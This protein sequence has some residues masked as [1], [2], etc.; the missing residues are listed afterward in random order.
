VIFSVGV[1]SCGTEGV[2]GAMDDG[3]RYLLGKAAQQ[4]FLGLIDARRID[5]SAWQD[6]FFAIHN[7]GVAVD[8]EG[9]AAAAIGA[10]HCGGN[11]VKILVSDLKQE[12]LVVARKMSLHTA[13]YTEPLEHA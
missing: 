9:T 4:G 8:G 5:R 10:S 3:R 1:R 2:Q 6:F 12:G 13:P 7:R 11:A